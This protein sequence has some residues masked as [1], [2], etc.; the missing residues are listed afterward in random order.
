MDSKGRCDSGMSKKIVY[1]FS[2]LIIVTVVLLPSLG[3]GRGSAVK[4]AAATTNPKDYEFIDTKDEVTVRGTR[5]IVLFP[6]G[7]TSGWGPGAT[8]KCTVESKRCVVIQFYD[9]GATWTTTTY[10][11]TRWDKGRI[12]AEFGVV[13][14]PRASLSEGYVRELASTC[15]ILNRDKKQ[16]LTA[17]KRKDQSCRQLDESLDSR[18]VLDAVQLCAVNSEEFDV[19]TYECPNPPRPTDKHGRMSP[20]PTYHISNGVAYCEHWHLDKADEWE[21]HV[22]ECVRQPQR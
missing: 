19:D 8:V 11:V 16:V 20:T 13:D 17:Q 5:W 7:G 1:Y 9:G 14:I 22:S 3:H 12:E 10:K 15:L 4:Q 6:K 21:G 18:G 2:A